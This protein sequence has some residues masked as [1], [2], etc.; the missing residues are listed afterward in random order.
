M[1]SYSDWVLDVT[2][3]TGETQGLVKFSQIDT[4]K[5]RLYNSGSIYMKEC[6][7]NLVGIINLKGKECLN[8]WISA[9]PNWY[10]KYQKKL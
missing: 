4:E 7:G 2:N 6:P 9:N 10:Y 5:N 8:A 3:C 1:R